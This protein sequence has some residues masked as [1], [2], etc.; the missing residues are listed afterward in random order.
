M[1]LLRKD[2]MKITI[3]S[4]V[5]AIVLMAVA[6]AESVNAGSHVVTFEFK[7]SHN[8]TVSQDRDTASLYINTSN[9]NILVAIAGLPY[10]YMGPSPAEGLHA[11]GCKNIEH[12]TVDGHDAAIGEEADGTYSCIYYSGHGWDP[13]YGE[14]T[15][16]VVIESSMPKESTMDFLESLHIST[17]EY[18]LGGPESINAGLYTITFDL[19]KPHR[20]SVLSDQ[21]WLDINI[22]LSPSMVASQR[23]LIADALISINIVD[24]SGP[25]RT[26]LETLRTVGCTNIETLQ[27]DGYDGAIG[28]DPEADGFAATY[29]MDNAVMAKNAVVAI[30]STL[31]KS[32]T[33]D[34][35]KT[36]HIVPSQNSAA[37]AQAVVN[38]Y[39]AHGIKITPSA[40]NTT[41][42][43]D[44]L[45]T[46][47]L[48]KGVELLDQGRY[49]EANRAF[50]KVI[51]ANPKDKHA[52]YNKGNALENLGNYDEAIKAYEEAI[53]IDPQYADAW[54]NKGQ[55][56][57]IQGKHD[58][59]LQCFVKATDADP[60]NSVAWYNKG[61][62][63]KTLGKYEE[64]IKAYDKAI[65]INP[66]FMQAW[67]NK[68]NILKKLGRT[69][70]AEAA[71]AKAK[72]LEHNAP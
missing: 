25:M 62:V 16:L 24:A 18:L 72:E 37:F 51:E 22:N 4:L 17:Y 45:A 33:I 53:R 28:A 47:W 50:D 39:A 29:Q 36:L 68:G 27:I 60:K 48:N 1:A 38:A 13:A 69:T 57:S 40:T 43:F 9:N 12:I 19:G 35:L 52:W 32:D 56:L 8:A 67:H 26:P 14:D 49:D 66:Q 70:E 58:D 30:E 10:D 63:L 64:A 15:T 21:A 71:F 7:E 2:K 54:I 3:C 65:E 42:G 6:S 59:A 20:N 11:T 41:F 5:L 61:V 55:A 23:D 34:F 31:S 44:G 46:D